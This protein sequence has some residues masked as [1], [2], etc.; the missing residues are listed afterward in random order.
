MTERHRLSVILGEFT[1]RNGSG[2][3]LN[4]DAVLSLCR[5]LRFP[6]ENKYWVDV[7]EENETRVSWSDAEGR[8]YHV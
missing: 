4:A 5:I 6:V 8:R 2:I 3:A 7:D 1:G